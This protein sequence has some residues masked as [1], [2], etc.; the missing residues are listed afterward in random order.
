MGP[1]KKNSA[2]T[3]PAAKEEDITEEKKMFD[4][5]FQGNNSLF[6]DDSMDEN[7]RSQHSENLD[8][9]VLKTALG[10][11]NDTIRL[12]QE[13]LQKEKSDEV[14]KEAPT[15]PDK[16]LPSDDHRTINVRMLDGENFVTEW[17][18]LTS[19]LPPPPDHGLRSPIVHTVLEQ[20]TDDQGLHASLLAWMERVMTGD[21]LEDSV[22][23][24]TISSL[25]HQVRDG[26]MMHVLPLLLRR[27]DIHVAVQ[28][29]AQRQTTYDLAVSVNQKQPTGNGHSVGARS[30]SLLDHHAHEEWHVKKPYDRD[31]GSHSAV[32]VPINNSAAPNGPDA[33]GQH[34]DAEYSHFDIPH[35]TSEDM[36]DNPQS[37]FMGALGGALGGLLSRGKYTA[38]QSPSSRFHNDASAPGF[39]PPPSA[40]TM[41]NA[42][43]SSNPAP[44]GNRVAELDHQPYHRVVSAPPGRIG[45]TFVEYRGHAMV[46]DMAPDSP[47][48]SWVFPSDILIAVDEVPVS[49]MRVRDI[50]QILT[51]RKD[52][53]RALRVIS[54]HAMN[55][56]T[57]NQSAMGDEEP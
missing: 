17:D 50:I 5:S 47:L 27:A 8:V 42:A 33:Q 44:S 36:D 54:S 45:V 10:Q 1:P 39:A 30:P 2:P 4:E 3:S 51:K 13:K 22:P 32:T 24:L 37:T 31:S 48:S 49:G 34:E 35:A 29:R 14:M 52:R 15:A 53:Q 46:A 19:P 12:L 57:L 11:A 43:S 20:W 38:V 28:M 18:D 23:P 26:F 40:Q 25:D 55:E 16:E 21:N 6:L 7:N 41:V 56:F 9:L